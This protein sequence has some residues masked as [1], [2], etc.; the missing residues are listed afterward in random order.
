M[1]FLLSAFCANLVFIAPQVAE[2][3]AVEAAATVAEMTLLEMT[4]S[5]LSGISRELDFAKN[6]VRLET[7]MEG[8]SFPAIEVA[9]HV[10][11]LSA[12]ADLSEQILYQL[13]AVANNEK[14]TY[15]FAKLTYDQ[16]RVTTTGSSK[17]PA[18]NPS[19]GVV[20]EGSVD[21]KALRESDA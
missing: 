9:A 6:V 3:A 8:L 16:L 17:T 13:G 14:T 4:E 18:V 20:G 1:R 19:P 5:A 11:L 15:E 21:V 2:A 10:Q 7:L 12:Y